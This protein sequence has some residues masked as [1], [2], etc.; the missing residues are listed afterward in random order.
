MKWR[1]SVGEPA[2]EDT[3][4]ALWSALRWLDHA[5][6]FRR[7]PKSLAS[8]MLLLQI[9][10]AVAVYIMVSVGL[11]W[12]TAHILEQSLYRQGEGWLA[13]ADELGTP[14]YA[15]RAAGNHQANLDYLANIPEI[16]SVH[17]FDATGK[18]LIY[19]YWRDGADQ[20]GVPWPTDAEMEL[21]HSNKG[22]SA[23]VA[24]GREPGLMNTFRFTSPIR[25]K[26]LR[27]DGLLSFSLDKAPS[28]SIKTIG[29]V[30]MRVDYGRFNA[31]FVGHALQV[32]AVIGLLLL[33]FTALGHVIVR[34]ALK[35]LTDL[36]LPLAR[37]ADG[38]TDV[39]VESSG[40]HEIVQISRALNTTI[41]AVRERDE[42]LRRMAN[43]DPLTGLANRIYF[44]TV[45][46]EEV[47][48][49]GQNDGSSALLF[50]DLDRFKQ[51]NDTYGHAAGD[52]LLIQVAELLRGRMREGDLI[53]RFGGDEFM[54]LVRGVDSHGAVE[55]A[56]SLNSLMQSFQFHENGSNLY[57]HFSIGI[58]MIDAA[59]PS[60]HEVLLRADKAAGEAKRRGRNRY[61]LYTLGEG[62]GGGE[63]GWRERLQQCLDTD[64][65]LLEFQ[66]VIELA[67]G[68]AQDF[69]VLVRLPGDGGI[70]VAPGAF[71][72]DAERYGLAGALDRQVLRKTLTAMV[73]PGYAKTAFAVNLSAQSL[74]EGSLCDWVVTL[75]QAAGIDPE[76]LFFEVAEMELARNYD[77]VR[78]QMQ[79][80]TGAGFGV[81][82][83]DFG[84]G[85]GSM[86]Y[87]RH[88]PV[89]RVKI[90]G[91][92]VTSVA[93]DRLNEILLK[94][95]IE[96]TASRGVVSVAK[97]PRDAQSL[98][99][100]QRL[101]IEYAQ[102]N[103]LTPPGE[104]GAMAPPVSPSVV[105][106]R[107]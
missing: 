99:L 106:L 75:V 76:R 58:A 15:G 13:K 100:L 59:A 89:A 51:I 67:T 82:I 104:L 61:Q 69:E 101:G 85:F 73:R 37:L 17:Y 46:S 2:E 55:I 45:L 74:L 102:G 34:W 29:Y 91:R 1:N 33:L 66:P 11:W 98:Q 5:N 31:E 27:D 56:A 94:A 77:Q 26:S 52:R 62:A 23:P 92:I 105:A 10:W 71:M 35:P 14:L 19:E 30:T 90:D 53:A 25:I 57:I 63:T 7:L 6:I 47:E 42:T 54:V 12:G 18:R 4:Q 96:A 65:L 8:R 80:L 95:I 103:L 87:L 40:D 28:E 49:I 68:R 107:H 9:T 48:A 36:Q 70:P 44:D 60:A 64:A 20:S 24:Y 83:D 81:T 97:F 72:A 78:A 39:Q 32:S 38:D 93:E 88:C 21:L 16:L 3:T 86:E 43:H 84:S 22:E 41:N 50:I 79:A